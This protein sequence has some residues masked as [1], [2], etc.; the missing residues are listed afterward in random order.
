VENPN[1]S[2]DV[3]DDQHVDGS[4][5][6]DMEEFENEFAQ[7][8][9][10]PPRRAPRHGGSILMAAM[11]GLAEALG[12]DPEPT[13]ITQPAAPSNGPDLDLNFGDLPPLD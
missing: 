3:G 2:G 10:R 12:W 6:I 4:E 7:E 9:K 5:T 1:Q 11:I 8:F 13:E